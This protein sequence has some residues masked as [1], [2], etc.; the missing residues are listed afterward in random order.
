MSLINIVVR[1]RGKAGINQGRNEDNMPGLREMK[2]QDTRKRIL[3][4]A[5]KM[6]IDKGYAQTTTADIA[7]EANIG[8]GT[9][10]NYFTTKGELFV[11]SIFE[12]YGPKKYCPEQ[13]S[14]AN[15]Q[16][17]ANETLK[18]LYHYFKGISSL[19][20]RA[21]REYFSVMYS[22]DVESSLLLKNLL[23][24][25]E[26]FLENLKEFYGRLKADGKIPRNFDIDVAVG[27]IYGSIVLQFT[28]YA[29]AEG[30]TTEALMHDLK[31]AI[32]F[33][34]YGHIPVEGKV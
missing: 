27:C 25:D 11:A 16:T 29:Y 18:M 30:Y 34:L 26:Q 31:K 21:L 1:K 10:F 6:F 19:D 5:T 17:L 24:A 3:K 12:G 13:L 7:R 2:K 22:S 20:K 33:I 8:E 14:D 4:C 32:S 15:G 9:L 23:K 28:I